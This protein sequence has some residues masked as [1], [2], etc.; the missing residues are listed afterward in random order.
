MPTTYAL[1]AMEEAHTVA[2]LDVGRMWDRLL[3]EFLGE[4]DTQRRAGLDGEE[5]SR[6]MQEFLDKLSDKPVEDIARQSS[7]VAYNQ[8]RGAALQT[9]KQA[10]RVQ[11]VVR[12]EVLDQATC[13]NCAAVD[14]A[15]VEVGTP[16]YERYMPPARCQ[17]GN[18]C[19]GFYVA[20]PQER[21]A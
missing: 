3:G 9:A 11:Y 17:G 1:K 14:G 4:W 10:K 5:L 19:R 13:A 20:L 16:E 15:I 21:A 12:S 6:H 7:T 8:G 18:R 2:L